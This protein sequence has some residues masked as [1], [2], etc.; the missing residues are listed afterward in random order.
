MNNGIERFKL[1]S[2]DRAIQLDLTAEVHGV[3]SA[4]DYF[5]RIPDTMKD[6]RLYESLLN[7]YARA[8]ERDMAESLMDQMRNKGYDN[9]PFP[10]NVMMTLYMKLDEFDKIDQLISEMKQKNVRLD[11]YSYNIWLSAHGSKGSAEGME[12]VLEQIKLDST[13]IPKWT[14]F[15]TM[16]SFYVKLGQIEKAED[17]LI[18]LEARITVQDNMAYRYLM[19]LYATLG[20]KEEVYRVWSLYKSKLPRVPNWGYHTVISA[21]LSLGDIEEAE[22]IYRE[23]LQGKSDYDPRVGNLLMGWY[24][25]EEH[26][27]KAKR[28]FEEMIEAGGRPN[29][30]SWGI[31]G[32]A[33]TKAGRISD[34]LSCLREAFSLNKGNNNTWKPKASHVSAFLNL[35]EKE[36]DTG[37]KDEF[38]WLLRELGC[39]QDRTYKSILA[40]HI[41]IEVGDHDDYVMFSSNTDADDETEETESEESEMLMSVME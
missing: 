17:C 6:N 8:K 5:V 15:G 19:T 18:N 3:S 29:S 33:H 12:H 24:A 31:I 38:V 26:F 39:F 16:A 23:W 21:L 11:I 28:F 7:A 41:G 25:R 37:S 10:F 2:I 36:G 1:S 14:T 13:L 32:E 40:G 34:T 22:K 20:K 4:E 35:C 27:E 30:G 9:G